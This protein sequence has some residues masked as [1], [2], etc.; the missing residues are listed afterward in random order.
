VVFMS[1]KPDKVKYKCMKCGSERYKVEERALTGTGAS[2]FMNI[3]RHLYYLVICEQ[4]GFVEM[5]KK[6]QASKAAQILDLFTS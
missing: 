6:G 4:C 5:Y 1:S 2:R 3:Q